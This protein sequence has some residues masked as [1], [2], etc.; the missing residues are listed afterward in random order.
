MKCF[1]TFVPES[2]QTGG[3][4][5]AA[6]FMKDRYFFR[7]VVLLCET[8][9]QGAL[10]YIL[11][12]KAKISLKKVLKEEIISDFPLY[13]GGPVE[14]NTLHYLHRIPS[15]AEEST[16]VAKGLYW[17][18]SFDKLLELLQKKPL[19]ATQIRFFVGY[20]GWDSSQL[21]KEVSELSWM[22]QNAPLLRHVFESPAS[23][24]WSE[25]LSD[26]GKPYIHFAHF[27]KNPALN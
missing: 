25:V 12:Q 14:R 11:N 15:L 21:T 19:N 8:G 1:D 26:M 5:L 20:S 2:P 18:K 17:G 22:V 27:P 24:L 6:P 4:L 9:E 13:I 23:A 10:G 16:P 7:A 3:L